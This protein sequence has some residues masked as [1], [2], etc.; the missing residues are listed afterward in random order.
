MRILVVGGGVFGVSCAWE[1]RLRGH[2][3][4]LFEK[5]HQC[6]GDGGASNDINRIV[7]ADYGCAC[8]VSRVL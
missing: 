2:D 4:T 8:P 5:S 3:V 6:P 7:R 1:L